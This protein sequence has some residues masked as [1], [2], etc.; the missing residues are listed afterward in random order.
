MC[1]ISARASNV[2]QVIPSQA[3]VGKYRPHRIISRGGFFVGF[4]SDT[5]GNVLPRLAIRGM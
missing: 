5:A 1:P 4:R 2:R 3:S